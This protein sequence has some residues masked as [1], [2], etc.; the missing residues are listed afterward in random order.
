MAGRKWTVLIM[1]DDGSGARQI[2]FSHYMIRVAV[3]LGMLVFCGLVSL[4]T[5]S[6]IQLH[7]PQEA[8]R[9]QTR[10][11]PAA[12]TAGAAGRTRGRAGRQAGIAFAQR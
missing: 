8:L 2:R 4:G 6:L 11:E 7:G 3:A 10:A 12:L 5:R 9:L 1:N